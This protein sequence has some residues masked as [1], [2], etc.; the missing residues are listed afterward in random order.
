MVISE[1]ISIMN[2]LIVFKSGIILDNNI[3]DILK[4]YQIDEVSVFEDIDNKT[5]KTNIDLTARRN[6]IEQNKKMMF[7]DCFND[8]YMFE[9]YRIVCDMQIMDGINE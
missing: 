3:I 5:I 6:E 8:E 1:E 9:L 2:G 7:K 4:K